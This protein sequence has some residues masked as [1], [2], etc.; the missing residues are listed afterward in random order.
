MV[1][2]VTNQSRGGRRMCLRTHFW[3]QEWRCCLDER[4]WWISTFLLRDNS[5][6]TPRPNSRIGWHPGKLWSVLHFSQNSRRESPCHQPW[7]GYS[8][9]NEQMEKDRTSKGHPRFNM[10]DHYSHAWDLMH[11]TWRYLFV[12]WGGKQQLGR[13]CQGWVTITWRSNLT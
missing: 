12:Q 4:I 2:R 7:H 11:V 6:G 3:R 1:V 5:K 9:C 10:V 13:A 8:E